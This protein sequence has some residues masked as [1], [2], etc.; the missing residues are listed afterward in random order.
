MKRIGTL[1]I[2]PL[3]W[4]LILAYRLGLIDFA[5]GGQLL[6]L[7]PGGAGRWS[8][9][10][11]YGRT[12]ARCGAGL[13]I[14]WMASFRS[15]H[16]SVGDRVYIGPFCWLGRVEIADGVMLGDHVTVL[17]GARHHD[18]DHL[19]G[20]MRDGPSALR[21]VRIGSRAWLGAGAIVMADVAPETAV[22]AGAVVTRAYEPGLI[23]AGVPA[24]PL[25]RRGES[26]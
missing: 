18:P 21:T 16:A 11:W 9:R 2:L 17:S 10:A 20:A 19:D 8:R 1:I 15:P 23:L 24:R 25:R 4:M 5:S 3:V 7:I 14:E 6:A 12:L 13:E 26:A 22:G